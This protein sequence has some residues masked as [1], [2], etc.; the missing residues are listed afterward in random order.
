MAVQLAQGVLKSRESTSA[1]W[2]NI[3]VE[4]SP[5]NDT[6]TLAAGFAADYDS[7]H[8]YNTGDLCTHEGG[9]YKCKTD[10]V[11]GTWNSTRW[12]FIDVDTIKSNIEGI[13]GDGQLDAS[14][15][16]T[17]LTGAANELK[18]TVG[19]DPLE[20]TAQDLSGG[21]N[22]LKNTLTKLIPIL[23]GSTNDLGYTLAIGM[24]FEYSG[25][26]YE[27]RTAVPNTESWVGKANKLV[28][29]TAINEI[30]KSLAVGVISATANQTNVSDVYTNR[31]CIMGNLICW[32][33]QFKI[34]S[35]LS[36]DAELFDLG[37][38]VKDCSAVFSVGDTGDTARISLLGSGK[39][40]VRTKLAD[41][42]AWYTGQIITF[43]N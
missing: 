8:T 3:M 30:Q 17:D 39:L 37:L 35:V 33:L 28:S 5:N 40:V 22:E 2:E 18:D 16:A 11:S 6:N 12:D 38:S 1:P 20:T 10:G 7:T 4:V 29:T 14:F 26:L 31:V 9:F 34:T 36:Y 41:T 23:T 42:N 19:S 15:T 32:S 13:I 27:V 43:Y 25:D 24:N 21:V